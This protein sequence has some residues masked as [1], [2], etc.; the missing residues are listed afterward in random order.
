MSK[1]RNQHFVPQHYLR[2][3]S[4]DEGKRIRLFNLASAKYV[5][6]A[7]LKHQCAS[8]CFYTEDLRGETI[9]TEIEGI[10]EEILKGICNKR[11]I[12][13]PDS[14]E[15]WDLMT[16]LLLMHTR[17]EREAE[18]QNDF[19][20][21]VA[22]RTISMS[23][24]PRS[25]EIAPN[26]HKVRIRDRAV[27]LRMAKSA[28]HYPHLLYDLT[29]RLIIAPDGM[30][31]VTSDHPVVFLN[32]A[33]F[34]VIRDPA[35]AGTAS[36]GLQIF[37][38]ISPDLLLLAFDRNFYRVGVRKR[39]FYQLERKE[40]CDIINALQILNCDRNIYFKDEDALPQVRAMTHRFLAARERIADR[41]KPME[42]PMPDGSPGFLHVY[43]QP[44]I[45]VPGPWSFCKRRGPVRRSDF[46]V[47]D[48]RLLRLVREHSEHLQRTDRSISFDDW[49]AEERMKAMMLSA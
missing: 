37:L 48:P 27:G 43:K 29:L 6:E 45:P 42:I 46:G 4:F 13:S 15:H 39:T 38:P 31:F 25:V 28:L 47:R 34:D 49:L 17:T 1:H 16:V 3:F 35:I 33:F 5:P 14:G 23:S 12:P 24:D 19:V 2:R 40:D 7:A 11:D 9:L 20:D 10:A 36:K 44:V 21:L 26:L 30:F 18:M 8:N 22:K 32:Q 41:A